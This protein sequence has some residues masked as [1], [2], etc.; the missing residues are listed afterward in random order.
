MQ[1]QKNFLYYTLG[2]SIVRNTG[3]KIIIIN[4]KK[5]VLHERLNHKYDLTRMN[6]PAT[7]DEK[8]AS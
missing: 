2:T 1:L 5:K 7:K 8:Q 4:P 3:T 6:A